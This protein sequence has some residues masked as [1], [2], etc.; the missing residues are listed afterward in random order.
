M[1][2]SR[3]VR[4]ILQQKPGNSRVRV[5]EN[6]Y[7]DRLPKA[8]GVTPVELKGWQCRI[9]RTRLVEIEVGTTS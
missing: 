1:T 9:Y 2:A 6:P 3:Q 5:S 8:A 4:Y 7:P